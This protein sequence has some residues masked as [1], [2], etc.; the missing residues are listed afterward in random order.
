MV[1]TAQPPVHVDDVHI[2][3]R[4]APPGNAVL[5]AQLLQGH[6]IFLEAPLGQ[7]VTLTLVQTLHGLGKQ[8]AAVVELLLFGEFDFLAFAFIDQPVLP[9]AVEIIAQRRVEGMV[10]TA[11]PPVH[12]DDVHIGDI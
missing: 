2:G 3:D 10:G 11:Q 5:P 4:A 9:F 1:G 6:R 7:D 12:V 8:L